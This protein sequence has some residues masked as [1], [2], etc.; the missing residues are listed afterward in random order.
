[1]PNHRSSSKASGTH[2]T[3]PASWSAVAKMRGRSLASATP[4][5]GVSRHSITYPALDS[6]VAPRLATALHD[7]VAKIIPQM[8]FVALGTA[9]ICLS[10]C[11][12]KPAEAPQAA[13]PATETPKASWRDWIAKSTD[14]DWWQEQWSEASAAAKASLE[15]LKGDEVKKRVSELSTALGSKDFI[16][17]ENLAAELGKHLSLDKLEQGI[18]FIILQRKDGG[19]AALKAINDYAAR[20]DLNEF[21]K[22]AAQNLQKTAAFLQRDDFRGWTYAAIFFACECKLG[23]HRGGLLA[24]PIISILF[25]DYL[26]KHGTK[27]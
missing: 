5:S 12:K 3:A 20:T 23:A 26:E 9:L 16:K 6:G 7:A 19:E 10:S 11:D 15:A 21:E 18:R 17:T 4:L 1:M 8:L 22:A 13:K 24:I 25:P 14:T 27:P 2:A